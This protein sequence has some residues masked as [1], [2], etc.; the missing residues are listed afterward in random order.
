MGTTNTIRRSQK[1]LKV[2]QNMTKRERIPYNKSRC[3]SCQQTIA[4][5]TF[6]LLTK[7]SP[8]QYSVC[9]KVG[10]PVSHKVD[11]PQKGY[12]KS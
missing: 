3:L 10:N 6:Y 2:K 9:W 7:M 1:P 5:T 4:T 11:K 12:K 8:F